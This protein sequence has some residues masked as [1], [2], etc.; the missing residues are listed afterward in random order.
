[1]IRRTTCAGYTCL[2]LLSAGLGCKA[3]SSGAA[4][5]ASSAAP[6]AS[7]P[8]AGSAD[9]KDAAADVAPAL[10]TWKGRYTTAPGPLYV[11]DGGEWAGV[12]WRGDDSGAGLGEGDISLEVN[13]QSG[14]VRGTA[15]G[16]IGEAVLSGDISGD[17]LMASVLRKDPLDRG[18]TGTAVLKAEGDKMEGT[19]KLTV[20]DARVIREAHVT[21]TREG[22]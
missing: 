22:R 20:S 21:L 13:R 7:A 12:R 4:T 1:M 3:S 17:T 2:V 9:V 19:M 16:A 6:S 14:A 15:T 10:E 8:T 5:T 18:F 11:Y